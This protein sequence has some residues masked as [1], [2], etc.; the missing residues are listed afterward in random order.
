M[1]GKYSRTSFGLLTLFI[2]AILHYSCN[3]GNKDFTPSTGR[4]NEILIITNNDALWKGEVGD[5]IRVFFGQ[6]LQGLPQAE[7]AFEMIHIP[8]SGFTQL[9]QTHHN[10]F[11]LDINEAVDKPI[12]ETKIDF[13]AKPQRVIKITVSDKN[14]F[15]QEFA[16][17][18]E[19][20]MQLFNETERARVINT[21]TFFEDDKIRKQL[22]KSYNVSM[23]FPKAFYIATTTENFVWLRREADKY[24]QG[25][26][27]Y[28]Y[29]YTDTLAF[30]YER[31]IHLRDS[32][33]KKYIPG[34]SDGSYMKTSMVVP[35]VK[36][37][38]NFND[39]F[40]VEM[41]GLW[42]LEGDFMGGPFVSYT[43]VDTCHN[44]IITID[45]YVYYPSQDKK[46]LVRQIEAI[47]YSFKIPE[48]EPAENSKN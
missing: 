12:V 21:N 4:S 36:K 16:A 34:P 14:S 30:N 43:F 27:M 37:Q 6:E 24:S 42:D 22:V 7:R 19:T 40:A 28:F 18:K 38:V 17:N 41:R 46:N 2:L 47:L 26:F 44:Q 5:T 3:F 15:Y 10:I 1:L 13:W 31:I 48:A 9:Y 20:F 11:I 39:N 25:V 32:I 23:V 29:P 8:A 35:P 33:T 45:G